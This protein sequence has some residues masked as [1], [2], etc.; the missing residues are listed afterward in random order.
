MSDT[1]KCLCSNCGAKYRLPVEA[2]GR[3][4]RCK[5][6]GEKF[7]VPVHDSLEDTILTWLTGAEAGEKEVVAQPRVISMPKDPETDESAKKRVRG[8]IRLKSGEAKTDEAK[9][10]TAKSKG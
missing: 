5:R 3:T 6:C 8:P 7:K 1:I 10:K 9:A 2:Q 4:A